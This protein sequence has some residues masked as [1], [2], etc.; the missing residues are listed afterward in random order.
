MP[1]A[2]DA[3][4]RLPALPPDKVTALPKLAPLVLN[5]TVPAGVPAAGATAVTVAVKNTDWP[6]TEGLAEDERA[7]EVLPLMATTAEEVEEQPLVTVTPR[8]TEPLALE[9]KET[10]LVAEPAVM[11]PPTIV[12]A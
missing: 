7:V 4:A 5:W 3:T 10:W 9:V 1:T 11:V 2:S 6:V 12:Q 8:V